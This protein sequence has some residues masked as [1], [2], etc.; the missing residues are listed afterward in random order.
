LFFA[1]PLSLSTI[2]SAA[3][4]S[5]TIDGFRSGA[6]VFFAVHLLLSAAF[7]SLLASAP[8]DGILHGVHACWV[9]D[10]TRKR[11]KNAVTA[12]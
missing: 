9:N 2:T 12:C 6:Y 5:A 7:A 3:F 8:F 11:L 4:A 10:R 1:V